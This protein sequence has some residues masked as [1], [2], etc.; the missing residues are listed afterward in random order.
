VNRDHRYLGGFVKHVLIIWLLSGSLE[1]MSTSWH[2]TWTVYSNCGNWPKDTLTSYP[3]PET[4]P[5]LNTLS[6]TIHNTAITYAAIFSP[7][8][9]VSLPFNSICNHTAARSLPQCLEYTTNDAVWTR[10]TGRHTT[11]DCFNSLCSLGKRPR[12]ISLRGMCV[13]LGR[14]RDGGEPSPRGW[15]LGS[16]LMVRGGWGAE[17]E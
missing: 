1:G 17:G 6:R 10:Y 4:I 9:L 13:G 14:V 2:S 12:V 5:F 8:P 11:V 16:L 3:L 7:P 15:G